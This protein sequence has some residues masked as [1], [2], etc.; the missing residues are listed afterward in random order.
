MSDPETPGHDPHEEPP[1]FLGSWAN[2]YKFV[3]CYLACLIAALYLFSRAF[4]P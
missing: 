3:I 2:V 1:P 4:A